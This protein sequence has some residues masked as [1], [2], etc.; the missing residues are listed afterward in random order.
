MLCLQSK[1]SHDE[2]TDNS[3]G[4]TNTASAGSGGGS[5]DGSGN[6]GNLS[7][8]GGND[9][10]G[11]IGAGSTGAGTVAG[12]NNGVDLGVNGDGG[13]VAGD[14]HDDGGVLGGLGVGLGQA[15]GL[16]ALL[17]GGGLGVA[18]V[19]DLTLGDGEGE[20]VL[21]DGGVGLELEDEA[22]DGGS[23]EV[24]IDVPGEGSLGVGNASLDI[25]DG[26]LEV[27]L[28]TT[29]QGD[30]DGL[31]DVGDG[32]PLDGESITGLK[33]L[34]VGRAG[35]NIEA[36]GGVLGQDLGNESQDGSGAER[37]LHLEGWCCCFRN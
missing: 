29:D 13:G 11:S 2:T 24:G 33:L 32:V 36:L 5:V 27:L 31:V 25:L 7:G 14:G 16:D 22:V 1:G 9:G 4:S 3:D 6:D 28:G 23:A 17:D 35:N 19:L 21:E 8:D 20:G 12:H 26:D 10:R 30:G 34:P 18:L 37:E 15:D